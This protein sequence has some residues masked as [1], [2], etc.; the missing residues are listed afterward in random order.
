MGTVISWKPKPQKPRP[1]FISLSAIR[2]LMRWQISMVLVKSNE[3]ILQSFWKTKTIRYGQR[4]F[5]VFAQVM[6]KSLLSLFLR[7]ALLA[8]NLIGAGTALVAV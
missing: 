6:V 2:L 1:S 5:M 8:A 3:I 7:L 4:L